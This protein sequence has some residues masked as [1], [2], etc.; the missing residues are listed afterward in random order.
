MAKPRARPHRNVVP[1]RLDLRDRPYTPAIRLAPPAEVNT[2]EKIK[3]RVRNQGDS[4]ACTGFALAAVID[5]LLTRAGRRRETPVSPFMLYSMAR[6]Y[7]E[8]R[9]YTA[10]EGSSCRGA[11]K[12]W[13]RHGVCSNA[14][15]KAVEMPPPSTDPARDWWQDAARRPLGAYYRVDTRSVTDMQ[16][17]L[18]EVGVLY[19]S[20]VA[21]E[22][23]DEGYDQIKRQAW[24]VPH[25]KVKP[26]DTGHAIAL[27]GYNRRGFLVLNSWG[28]T[29][30]QS[31]VGILTYEDWLANA[32]DCWVVQ[33]GVVTDL[34]REVSQAVSLR[35]T[36]GRVELAGD[37][38][39]RDRELSPFIVNVENNGQLSAS[40]KFRTQPSDLTA[41]A[42]IHLDKAIERWKLKPGEA[43]DVALYAHGGLV[44]EEGA[45]DV[46]A[47]WVPALY[48]ARILPVFIMWETDI[49]STLKN[50]LA[51]LLPGDL[52]A[53]ERRTAG[54]RDQLQRWWNDRLERTFARPGAFCWNEM[55]ENAVKISANPA[56]GLRQLYDEFIKREPRL[57]RPVRF[58]LI[59]HSA[60]A[61]VQTHLAANLVAA[62]RAIDSIVLMAAAVRCD[63]FRTL[64][65]P[66]L[67]SRIRRLASFVLDDETE[68][69]D[70]TCKALFGYERSLLYLVSESFETERRHMPIVGMQKYFVQEVGESP[71]ISLFVSPREKSRS[72]THGGFDDDRTTLESVVAFIK[73]GTA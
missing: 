31:G 55:K 44:G 34:H 51:D 61:I 32:M 60:G 8:F 52:G 47:R 33:L 73:Y 40:G 49:L 45:A 48:D 63:T 57:K 3:V 23:W 38:V 26:I 5:L 69:Q 50:T 54:V 24:E 10:D 67:G 56:G 12:A 41:L 68:Q 37:K 7:D 2:L 62:G 65:T 16:V 43:I 72:T 9:G 22:G 28:P 46:A 15:W 14:W 1:D 20:V 18:N 35:S 13:Y 6:R 58:H 42:E 25:R 39:L 59:G 53:T 36:R 4:N 27:V 30:G 29:W 17:A 70:P 66:H 64:V 21:H 71:A 11:L 19:S